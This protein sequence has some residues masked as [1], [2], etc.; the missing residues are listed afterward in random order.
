M[1]DTNEKAALLD[2]TGNHFADEKK[3]RQ[4]TLPKNTSGIRW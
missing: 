4:E 1:T 3:I 2:S